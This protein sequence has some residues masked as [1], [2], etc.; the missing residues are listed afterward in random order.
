MAIDILHF[1]RLMEQDSVSL[2]YRG[3][4]SQAVL[5]E[6]GKNLRE[7]VKKHTANRSMS[8]KVF[9]VF[10]E[11]A[12]NVIRYADVGNIDESQ[13]IGQTEC[14]GAIAVGMR[15]DHY[16]ICCGNEI[17]AEQEKVIKPKLEIIKQM[18]RDEIK[19]H[20]IAQRKKGPDKNSK[21]GGIGFIE[22]AKLASQPIQYDFV[23]TSNGQM[24]FS[25]N[26]II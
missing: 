1:M 18:N 23:P 24:F 8:I 5:M 16:F 19:A 25:L 26:V 12:Q 15:N 22:I 11:L 20:F 9:S 13:L 17:D 21:G 7:N 2:F 14:F 4:F 10:V 6:I 3:G